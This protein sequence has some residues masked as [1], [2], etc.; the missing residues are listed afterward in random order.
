MHDEE[1]HNLYYYDDQSVEK[2]KPEHVAYMQDV[3]NE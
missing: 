1:F 2:N 3:T